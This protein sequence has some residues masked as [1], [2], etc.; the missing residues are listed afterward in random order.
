MQYLILSATALSI[1]FVMGKMSGELCR[2]SSKYFNGN[3]YC[4]EVQT[5]TYHNISQ[6]GQYNRTTRVDPETGRC[7]HDTV[8]YSG[9]GPLTPL[10]GEVF[11]DSSGSDI[12]KY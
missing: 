12:H 8:A 10:F 4:S 9:K 6:S 1:P 7:T 3:W 11:G 2:G 5:I